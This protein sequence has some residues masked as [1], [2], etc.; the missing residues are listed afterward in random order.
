MLIN[1][2]SLHNKSPVTFS[3]EE[4]EKGPESPVETFYSSSCNYALG[5][6]KYSGITLALGELRRYLIQHQEVLLTM[7]Y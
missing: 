6:S 4:V 7:L 2:L 3:I 5:I 1:L